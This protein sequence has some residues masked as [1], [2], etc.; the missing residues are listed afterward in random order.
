MTIPGG[1]IDK[2]NDF[3]RIEIVTSLLYL[4][5]KLDLSDYEN[6]S[7]FVDANFCERWQW[8]V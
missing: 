1:P 5:W 3:K 2:D 6:Y 4:L 8:Y 7:S